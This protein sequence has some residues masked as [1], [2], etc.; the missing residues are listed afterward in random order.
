MSHTQGKVTAGGD[1]GTMLQ[2]EPRGM[3]AYVSVAQAMGLTLD[4]AQANARRVAACWNA[5]DG[6]PTEMI[7]NLPGGN[8]TG[9][10]DHARQLLTNQEPPCPTPSSSATAPATPPATSPS[11][12]SAPAARGDAAT[13]GPT[14]SPA[15]PST[16][17]PA[18]PGTF[19]PDKAVVEWCA[20]N[21]IG[22]S[23]ELAARNLAEFATGHI[24]TA[25]VL[26]LV[27][28]A[29]FRLRKSFGRSLDVLGDECDRIAAEVG[30]LPLPQ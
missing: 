7:E 16:S 22:L 26:Y 2:A 27:A 29:L 11:T 6:M 28:T 4:E 15:A 14:S 1:R 19:K 17:A 3:L 18:A 21:V 12:T 9:L 10:L 30:L 20:A 24:C 23:K 5:F 8:V 25:H 13:A